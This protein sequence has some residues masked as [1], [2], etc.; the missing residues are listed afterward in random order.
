LRFEIFFG[1][2]DGSELIG[3]GGVFDLPTGLGESGAEAVGFG[4]VF[5]EAGFEALIGEGDDFVRDFGFG[6]GNEGQAESVEDDGEAIA[7]GGE[8][9]IFGGDG[10]QGFGDGEELAECFRAIQVVAKRGGDGG[11]DAEMANGWQSG[12]RGAEVLLEVA[13]ASEGFAGTD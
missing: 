10:E 11:E 2:L 13:K 8:N 6:G 12:G 3:I 7:M 1:G 9:G 4:P 5:A